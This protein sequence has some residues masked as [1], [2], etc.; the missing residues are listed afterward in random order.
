[1][2]PKISVITISYNAIETIEETIK[3][4]ISQD[5][6]N[7]EYI[8]IDGGS[9]DGTVDLIKKYED[10]IDYWVSEK[11]EGLYD[12][13]NKGIKISRGDVIG[14]IN[15]DDLY[16]EG[17]LE[18]V[19]KKFKDE[20]IDL[21][22]GNTFQIDSEN[23]VINKKIARGWN[24]IWDGCGAFYHS[25][26]FFSRRILDKVGLYNTRYQIAGDIDILQRVHLSTSRIRIVDK[27]LTK[28][29]VGGLSHRGLGP[30]KGIWEYRKINMSNGLSKIK[31]NYYFLKNIIIRLLVEIRDVL[32]SQTK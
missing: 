23:E 20:E 1:M 10:E 29:R 30:Y 15:A 17:A 28:Q 25:S 32:K 31:A 8:I 2:L 14:Q 12:G 24:N 7:L 3:S 6:P 22:Y 19:G 9:N 16:V 13:L 5:Y 11:D 21:L 26:C 18:I 4:V 27:F